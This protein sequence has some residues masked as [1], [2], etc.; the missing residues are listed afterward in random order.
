MRIARVLAMVAVAAVAVVG[1]GD[2]DDAGGSGDET[3]T[4]TTEAEGATTTTIPPS[5][6]ND[7]AIATACLRNEIT[8]VTACSGALTNL[9]REDPD[10]TPLVQAVAD[11][12]GGGGEIREDCMDEAETLLAAINE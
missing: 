11:C 10:L 6:P 8:D 12:Q 1:C 3:T 7:A 9:L 4:T 2:D 5:D